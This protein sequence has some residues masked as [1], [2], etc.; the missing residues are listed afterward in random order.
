MESMMDLDLSYDAAQRICRS[1]GSNFFRSFDFLKPDRRRAMHALYAYARIADDA[2]DGGEAVTPWESTPWIE[3]LNRL[4]QWNEPHFTAPE[5]AVPTDLQRIGAALSD[6]VKKFQIP[7]AMLEAL[8]QGME[9][10]ARGFE[11]RSWDDLLDYAIH[12]ASSIGICCTAI[13]TDGNPVT[14]AHPLWRSAIDCGAA[15]QLTNILRDLREDAGRGRIYIPTEDLQRFGIDRAEW[16]EILSSRRP[17]AIPTIDGWNRLLAVQVERARGLF[18]SGWQLHRMLD[19]DS[20]RM[21]SLMWHTYRQILR[22]IEQEPL[23]TLRQRIR[24][25]NMSKWK[26]ASGHCFTPLLIR[27]LAKTC[28]ETDSF[29]LPNAAVSCNASPRVAVVGGGLAGMSAAMHL[30]RH[31]CAVTLFEAKSRLGGRAGSF[32]DPV[33]NQPIDYCQHVGMQ[34]CTE[35]IRWIAATGSKERW[36]VSETLH[37]V[38]STGKRLD[39][40]AW[41]LPAP[42]HLAGLIFG[43]PDLSWSD[44]VRVAM[45]LSCLL[46]SRQSSKFEQT[47]ALTWLQLHFQNQRIIER[48]WG[49]ILVSALGEQ[50]DRIAMGPVRKVLVDGFAA[51]RDAF[52]LLIP[53]EPLSQ[54]M[55]ANPRTMLEALKVDIRCG[56]LIQTVRRS[57]NGCWRI[58]D[59]SMDFDTIVATVPWHRIGDLLQSAELSE[60]ARQVIQRI[61]SLESSPITGVHTWWDRPW[62][63]QPHAILI[64]RL[65]QWIFPGPDTP[66]KQD[67]SR[68]TYYQVVISG[69]R[70]LP[71]GDHAAIL[72]A[73]EQDL[74]Q[75]FPKARSARMLRGKVVT[76]PQS[77]YSVSPDHAASRPP[78]TALAAQGLFLGGDWI[79][80]GWPATMEGALRSGSLAAQGALGY[81]GRPARWLE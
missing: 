49:T 79:V 7:I 16:F 23:Q 30:A 26:L 43:W 15:F 45:G 25:S 69:S 20:L 44:R 8:V 35:L 80:T 66:E 70:Q 6:S 76:D 68:D 29:A 39:V 40:R 64:D 72:Q 22:Q 53:T 21:F 48:F 10:D 54:L 28:S 59:G 78:A 60:E 73:V 4:P 24:L 14:P 61:D 18:A 57:D 1:S 2:I 34:C 50:V 74:C 31:G 63:E 75:V 47:P 51:T 5:S 19:A 3:W 52:H 58:N 11:V 32:L 13:W 33:T 67:S 56:T 38:S 55:D 41:P 17:D 42:L 62:L 65:C 12:V 27:R 9:K 77:V 81:L 37:F 36:R 71:R 46:F